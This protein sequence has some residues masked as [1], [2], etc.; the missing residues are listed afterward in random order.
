MG[1]LPDGGHLGLGEP[2][3][4]ALA[5]QRAALLLIRPRRPGILSAAA[6]VSTA[7][8]PALGR[9]GDGA[10][11]RQLCAGLGCCEEERLWWGFGCFH[12]P[13]ACSLEPA[14]LPSSAREGRV[15][16]SSVSARAR[17][18]NERGTHGTIV[19]C[20]AL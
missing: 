20:I 3:N 11:A 10:I 13:Q 9:E 1:G 5:S 12:L 6:G 17:R 14:S 16:A 2:P 15:A 8:V 18:Q 7:T 4:G 19:S